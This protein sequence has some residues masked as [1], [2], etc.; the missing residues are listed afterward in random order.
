MPSHHR[1]TS[2][3]QLHC[4]QNKQF[5][6]LQFFIGKS[7]YVPTKGKFCKLLARNVISQKELKWQIKKEISLFNPPIFFLASLFLQVVFLQKKIKN[8]NRFYRIWSKKNRTHAFQFFCPLVNSF[9]HYSFTL[10]FNVL[11]VVYFLRFYS[12]SLIISIDPVYDIF[13]FAIVKFFFIFVKILFIFFLV[14]LCVCVCTCVSVIVYFLLREREG[15]R[16]RE[17]GSVCVYSYEYECMHM[18]MV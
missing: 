9:S 4:K 13:C 3:F 14:C 17:I 15:E 11:L 2:T 8:K 12:S 7:A 5:L 1:I 10:K 16:E 18:Y 6:Y